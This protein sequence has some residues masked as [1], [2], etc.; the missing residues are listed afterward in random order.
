[1]HVVTNGH[2]KL[3]GGAAVYIWSFVPTTSRI[4]RNFLRQRLCMSVAFTLIFE[5]HSRELQ[6][7]QTLPMLAGQ[8]HF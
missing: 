8:F 7:F 2:K 5:S 4:S 1:M 6:H 3:H